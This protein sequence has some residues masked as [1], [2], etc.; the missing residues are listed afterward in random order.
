MEH[1]KT[2]YPP[3]HPALHHVCV[4]STYYEVVPSFSQQHQ[5]HHHSLPEEYSNLMEKQ[6]WTK[7]SM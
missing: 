2:A 1:E 6:T 3:Q 7:K 5:H 4:Q